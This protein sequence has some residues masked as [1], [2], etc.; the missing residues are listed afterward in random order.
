MSANI[1]DKI[2]GWINPEGGARRMR[3]RLAFDHFRKYDAAGYGRRVDDWKVGNVSAN[4]E[5]EMS[6]QR[7][8]ARSRD[9]DRNNPYAK[10]AIERIADNVVGRG[11]RPTFSKDI[12]KFKN[13]WIA[14]AEGESKECDFDGQLNFYGIQWLVMRTVA[15]SGS[16]FIRKRRTN[17][18]KKS[19][20]PIQLQVFEPDIIDHSRNYNGF[21]KKA[22]DPQGFLMQGIEFDGNGQRIGYWMWD[23]YP[24]ETV[25]LINNLESK[26]V[27]AEDVIHVYQIERPGQ[28]HGVPFGVQSFLRVKDFD[29]FED[30]ELMRQKIAA[31]FSAFVTE[32]VSSAPVKTG[33][34]KSPLPERV[35]PGIIERLSPGEQISFGNPPTKEGFSDYSRSVLRGIAAGY[36]VTYEGL[37]GD[38]TAVNFSSGRMGWLEFNRTV[39][40]YQE[41]MFIPSF[42]AGAFSWFLEGTKV[43][44]VYLKD[45]VGAQWTTPKREMI[46]PS[47]E[48]S[49]LN[50]TVRNG[51]MD[52]GEAVTSLGYDPETVLDNIEKYNKIFDDKKIIL[53]SDPRKTQKGGKNQLAPPNEGT[54]SAQ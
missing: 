50:E 6:I 3:A 27:P 43:G 4:R 20:I 52:W 2:I 9:L 42:C 54:P 5:T 44:M 36:G 33:G 1:L 48:I 12:K 47:K 11:I 45:D 49:A 17:K 25:G 19:G 53:D 24:S 34:K 16:C 26:F 21:E 13:A 28:V 18:N 40:R 14:W 46:D 37:T 41:N 31:C 10:R 32:T 15:E 29:D 35:E 39:E 22:K 8:I 7:L 38:M 51:F 30:A 23:R